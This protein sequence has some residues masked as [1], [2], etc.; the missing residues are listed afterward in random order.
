MT[1]VTTSAS[2]G[3]NN[4]GVYN[5]GGGPIMIN[6]SVIIGS[7]RT[8]FNAGATTRVGNTKLD[9]GPVFNSGTLTCVW[10]YDGNY[11]ALNTSCSFP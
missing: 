10:A 3:T 2:G 6:N 9:G 8:L 11:V 5:A 7:T 4:W 1:N